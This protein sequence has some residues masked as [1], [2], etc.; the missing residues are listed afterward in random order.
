MKKRIRIAGCGNSSHKTTTIPCGTK[1]LGLRELSL[2][3]IVRD[4]LTRQ[5]PEHEKELTWFRNQASLDSA[6]RFAANAQD[7]RGLRYSHQRRIK[8]T[9]I[10]E[11][12]RSLSDSHD[13]LK[14][15]HTFHKLWEVIG[16]LLAPVHGIGELYIYDTAVRIGAY[17]GLMPQK[18]YLHAGTRTGARNL[19]VIPHVAVQWLESKELPVP[20]R[21]L[22]S[23]DV[24]NLLCIY[25]DDLPHL[26]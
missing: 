8:S 9:A 4:Y 10:A 19:R 20:L 3:E 13:G 1:H 22:P 7:E 25:K 2:S 21:R 23:S 15:S 12:A 6:I 17:L 18:V 5:Q 16:S 11:A 14:A 26:N 24:E